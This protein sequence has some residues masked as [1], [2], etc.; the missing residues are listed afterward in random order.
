M[1][2]REGCPW[3]HPARKRVQYP[4][5]LEP[6]SPSLRYAW[7]RGLGQE[8]E[9]AGEWGAGVDVHPRVQEH[10]PMVGE[11]Q[12]HDWATGGLE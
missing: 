12:W 7:A 9:D 10:A 8:E 5:V 11:N 3:G 1:A 6:S 4:S 2:A